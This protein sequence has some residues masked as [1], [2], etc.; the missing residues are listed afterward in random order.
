MREVE[1]SVVRLKKFK[2][3]K[4][5]KRLNLPAEGWGG[6]KVEEVEEVE[7]ASRRLGS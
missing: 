6:Q 5:L 1:G 3:L 4:W 2:G 7:P